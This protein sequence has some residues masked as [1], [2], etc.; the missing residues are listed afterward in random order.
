MQRLGLGAH[1]LG[2]A[3]GERVDD[4][5][6]RRAPGGVEIDKRAVLVEQHADEL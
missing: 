2:I 4:G 6:R 5:V 3:A 1:Q